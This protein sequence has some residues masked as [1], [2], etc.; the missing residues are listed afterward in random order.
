MEIPLVDGIETVPQAKPLKEYKTMDV[1]L[2]EIGPVWLDAKKLIEE[3]GL[4]L[5]LK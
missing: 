5:E 3:A 2:K 1:P 4:D